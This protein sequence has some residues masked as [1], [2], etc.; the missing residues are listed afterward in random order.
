ML[1]DNKEVI[2]LTGLWLVVRHVHGLALSRLLHTCNKISCANI[3]YYYSIYIILV[4]I[5]Y[6]IFIYSTVCMGCV[7]ILYMLIIY[8]QGR[9]NCRLSAISAILWFLQTF[10]KRFC[11]W[12]QVALKMVNTN[13]IIL[14]KQSNNVH[15][16]IM[17]PGHI[18]LVIL[19]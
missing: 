4:N 14:R 16:M 1:G 7:N 3:L 2:A 8:T 18:E 12:L 5:L 19:L 13:E 6:L 17:I 11:R 15:R 9:K 10:L